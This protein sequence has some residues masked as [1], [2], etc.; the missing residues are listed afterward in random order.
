MILTVHQLRENDVYKDLV[1]I[2]EAHRKDKD[3]NRI[4][5]STICEVTVDG[6][7][8]GR[9]VV[10]VRGSVRD[11][12][13]WIRM[14]D[15]TRLDLGVTERRDYDFRLTRAGWAKQFCWAW[16]ASDPTPRIAARLGLVSVS[17]GVVGFLLGL[18][19]FFRK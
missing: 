19:S 1:R 12:E 17:L 16:C 3:G 10:C 14:H 4:R 9:T 2:P 11:T 8:T 18:L 13:P 6:G 7:T 5:E 15:K